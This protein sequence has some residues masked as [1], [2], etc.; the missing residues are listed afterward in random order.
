M[1]NQEAIEREIRQLKRLQNFVDAVFALVIVLIVYDLPTP[2]RVNWS[3]G[4]LLAFLAANAL[5]L[6][7]SVIGLILVVN[8]WLQN[9][10]L[11]GCLKR[12]DNRHTVVSIVQ[13][14]LLLFY[15]YA[16]GLSVDIRYF[17]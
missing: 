12:T 3:G 14:F 2:S 11:F 10:A 1:D 13:I 9:N 7:L 8:Y 5:A 16:I 4:T 17:V 6:S 15:L